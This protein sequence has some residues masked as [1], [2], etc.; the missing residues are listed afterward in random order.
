MDKI[1]YEKNEWPRR[2]DKSRTLKKI[3]KKKNE[4]NK[5]QQI[6]FYSSSLPYYSSQ[7][8]QSSKKKQE[9]IKQKTTKILVRNIPFEAKRHEVEELFK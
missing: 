8:K 9:E 6:R 3:N 4:K 5:T 1:W 2:T 7:S